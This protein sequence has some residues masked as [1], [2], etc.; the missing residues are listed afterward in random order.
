MTSSG[1]SPGSA[2]AVDEALSASAGAADAALGGE[3]FAPPP[4]PRR[5]S[6]SRIPLISAIVVG[7]VV[8]LLVAVLATSKDASQLTVAPSPLQNKPAPEISG[9][10]L[11]GGNGALS[12]FK[13]KWVLINFFASWCVPCQQEQG[14]LVKFQNTHAASGDAVIFGVRFDDPDTGP[15]QDL[16][17]KSGAQWPIVDAPNANIAYGVTGPPESFLVS[18]G[19]IV[20]AHIIGPIT[21][22]RLE[23]LLNQ[24]KLVVTTP[25]QAPSLVGPGAS[26]P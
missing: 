16:M 1:S 19:G 23:D 14:D 22:S 10:T 9:P 8:A 7:C 18:P 5:R 21:D 11:G 26:T 4:P 13:G 17:S 24:E 12:A 20:L 2:G 3:E 15:I 6:R 25:T